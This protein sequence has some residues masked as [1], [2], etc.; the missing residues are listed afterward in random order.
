MQLAVIIALIVL[1]VGI[2]LWKIYK[3]HRFAN[4]R[5]EDALE[6]VAIDELRK[7]DSEMTLERM[8]YRQRMYR[9]SISGQYAEWKRWHEKQI[10][11]KMASIKKGMQ[12]IERAGGLEKYEEK[13]KSLRNKRDS[14]FQ[15]EIWRMEEAVELY[16][17]MKKTI[18]TE[19]E[20]RRIHP[21]GEF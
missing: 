12:E 10:K 8:C 20:Y 9:E 5:F 19:E 11:E 17:K 14:A 6:E 15:I 2:P 7:A 16:K 3:K 13:I 18:L 4:K 1:V 21:T